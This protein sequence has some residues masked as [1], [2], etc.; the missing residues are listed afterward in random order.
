MVE[1]VTEAQGQIRAK[2]PEENQ[3]Y[4]QILAGRKVSW[5]AAWSVG[6]GEGPVPAASEAHLGPAWVSSPWAAQWV[7]RGPS[8]RIGWDWVPFK[9]HSEELQVGF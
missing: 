1:A 4:Q 2:G 6:T 8:G 7:G 3:R 9:G 5:D